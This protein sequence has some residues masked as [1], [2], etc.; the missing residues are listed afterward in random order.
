MPTNN[1]TLHD[2]VANTAFAHRL[3]KHEIWQNNLTQAFDKD[4]SPSRGYNN[5]FIPPPPPRKR[6]GEEVK[7]ESPEKE[8]V[9]T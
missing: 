6:C 1:V 4:L 9:G 8:I 2:L 5:V 7:Y 3:Q